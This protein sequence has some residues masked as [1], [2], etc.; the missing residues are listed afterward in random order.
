MAKITILVPFLCLLARPAWAEPGFA[1]PPGAPL[2]P[3][4]APA[5]REFSPDDAPPSEYDGDLP[6]SN[7]RVSVG[8]ALRVAEAATDGGLAAA[9]DLG[10]GAVGARASGTWVRVGSDQGTSEYGADLWIDFGA[11]RRLHPVV[12]AGAAVVRTSQGS[13]AGARQAWTYGA[14][15]LRGTLEYALPVERSDARAGLDLVGSLPAIQARSAPDLS[16]W[17]MITARVGIG[18]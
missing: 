18:F 9:V 14:G 8:P 16:P 4:P 12:G 10:S 13:A 1:T 15:V 6:T 2:T 17:L 7:V 5:P 3:Q 11:G